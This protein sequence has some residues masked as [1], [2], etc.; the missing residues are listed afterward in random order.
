MG[1]GKKVARAKRELWDIKNEAVAELTA[2]RERDRMAYEEITRL[3]D[4]LRVRTALALLALIC[5]AVT[6]CAR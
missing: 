2:A 5:W 3:R 4:R 6:L 1:L